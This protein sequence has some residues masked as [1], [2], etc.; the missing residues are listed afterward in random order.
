MFKQYNMNQVILPL[1]LEMKLQENDIAYAVHDLVEQIPNEAFAAFLRKTGCPAY[2]PRMM[3]KIIVCAYTQSV[4]SGRKIEAL[5][6]DSV[7]M[8]WLAQGYEPS[9][10]TINRFRVHP[11]VQALLRECFVQF[12]CQLVQEE[13]ID[14]EAIFI[15]G[16]KIEANA[17]KF[18][19][20]WRKAVEN[21][22]A[23]L[24]EKSNRM[25]DEL[26]EKEIIPE[27]VRENPE[28]LS[29]KELTDIAERLEEKV[30]EWSQKIEES[31]EVSER[32]QLRS[33]RKEPKQSHK[34]FQ[35][36][37]A[38][39]QKYESDTEIFGERNSYSK[40]DHDATFMRMK[41]DYMKNGQLKAGYNIQVATEG[42][43]AL[44]Y[45]VFPNPTDTRTFL[46]FLD[47][48]EQ[49]FFEL[50]DHLVA[51]SGYGSEENYEEVQENRKRTPLITYNTYR[52]EKK[53][54][55]KKKAFH[56]ANWEYSEEDDAFIC[57]N[58]KQLT[59]RYFSHKTD[60]YGFVR[61]FKVYECEDCSGCPLRSQCTKAKE[62]NNRKIYYNEKWEE[63]KHMVR[64]LLSEEKMGELYGKRKVDVEPFFGF[65][66]ANLRFTRMSVRG[67]ESVKNELGFAFM[68]VNLRKYTAQRQQ[69]KANNFP[70]SI[71]KGSDHQK[72]MIG[73][74]FII[75]G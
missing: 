69:S 35:D 46:P 66:K 37:A 27:I 16:T 71:K 36:F 53:K 39:K 13:L 63:Q 62:G 30:E 29:V 73:T 18:T 14:D 1:D 56:S 74:F 59:F 42:Q 7:R 61:K 70:H 4:F 3:M 20:V 10:R 44:A 8:M 25:Y 5:L 58:G 15:D 9:Y 52:K 19:F 32:K 12:R 64:E 68:A 33:E 57:P 49:H 65:L 2:H 28:E 26:V 21:Y 67:Q 22:N 17:N 31:E 6:Q 47:H 75:S 40:T 60:R 51:D 43:Y 72:P 55:F 45:D 38:R 24:I 48:I 50:P 41:D 23:N 11:D 54:S 34:Q